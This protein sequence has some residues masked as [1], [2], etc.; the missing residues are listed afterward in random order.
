MK[1]INQIEKFNIKIND[2]NNYNVLYKNYVFIYHN[3]AYRTHMKLLNE[4]HCTQFNWLYQKMQQSYNA[5]IS[6][7]SK[8]L[9]D[10]L[11]RF[12]RK[13]FFDINRKICLCFLF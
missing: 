1:E 5:V 3:F 9:I 2:R 12:N 7:L 11:N 13:D 10:I 8:T 6:I 4:I